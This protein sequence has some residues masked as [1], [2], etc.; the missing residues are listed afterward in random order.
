MERVY[1]DLEEM[2]QTSLYN[3][4]REQPV[5]RWAVKTRDCPRHGVH[6]IVSYHQG[7]KRFL[8]LTLDLGLKG[9]RIETSH[10]FPRDEHLQIQLV[11]GRSSIHV[12]G[13]IIYSRLLSN[14]QI[15][16]GIHFVEVSEKDRKLLQ[17]CLDA[18]NDH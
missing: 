7:D 12:R 2:S 18:F 3:Y 6:K 4:E 1:A 11:L 9:M 14:R 8:T 13:R 16:T 17:D 10:L 15:V 5:Y